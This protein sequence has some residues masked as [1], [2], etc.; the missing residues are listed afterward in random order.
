ML[1]DFQTNEHF[2]ATEVEADLLKAKVSMRIDRFKGNTYDISKMEAKLDQARSSAITVASK[3]MPNKFQ[4]VLKSLG[5]KEK[6]LASSKKH[7]REEVKKAKKDDSDEQEEEEVEVSE[8]S[9]Q[10]S[11][12]PLSQDSSRPSSQESSTISSMA[13]TPIKKKKK[14]S[15]ITKSPI[16]LTASGLPAGPALPNRG[17]IIPPC[18][19]IPMQSGVPVRCSASVSR[20][21]KGSIVIL[22]RP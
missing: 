14:H 5:I 3:A 12:K 20:V 22:A 10:G 19:S 4:M 8:L 15:K 13:S 17:G 7:K 6:K 9:S 21:P 16:A 2:E 18:G 11:S 1:E